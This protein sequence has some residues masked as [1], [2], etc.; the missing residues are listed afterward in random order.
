MHKAVPKT[1]KILSSL[2]AFPMEYAVFSAK[3]DSLIWLGFYEFLDYGKKRQLFCPHTFQDGDKFVITGNK[4]SLLL[5][6]QVLVPARLYNIGGHMS[7]M[8][9]SSTNLAAF[10]RC[11][12]NESLYP[13]A[14]SHVKDAGRHAPMLIPDTQVREWKKTCQILPACED[15]SEWRMLVAY[16]TLQPPLHEMVTST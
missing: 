8:A 11:I 1:T 16:S 6:D 2:A 9:G 5:R 10:Q 4:E 3:P 12:S 13:S 14:S 15:G 7:S